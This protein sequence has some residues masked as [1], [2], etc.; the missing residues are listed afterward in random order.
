M[1]AGIRVPGQ[2][3]A[4]R[5]GPGTASSRRHPTGGPGDALSPGL[6]LGGRTTLLA[7]STFILLVIMASMFSLSLSVII[8]IL[9]ALSWP[10]TAQL[11]RGQVLAPR[12]PEFVQAARALGATGLGM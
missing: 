10:Y 11:I 7:V 9:T 3:R 6:G 1:G 8:L 4:L 2:V 12:S 5:P